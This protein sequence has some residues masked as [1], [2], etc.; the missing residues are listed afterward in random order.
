MKKIITTFVVGLCLFACSQK[1]NTN[2]LGADALKTESGL[3]YVYLSK[4]SGSNPVLGEE[5]KAHCILKV[6]DSTEIWNTR[7]EDDPYTFVYAETGFIKGWIEIMGVAKV[8]DRIKVIIPPDMGYG[9]G[10]AGDDIPG[11]A[12]LSFDIE[13]LEST[14]VML[15]IA[16]SL[17]A[18]YA[19]YGREA[20]LAFYNRLKSDNSGKYLL[21]EKQL[22]NLAGALRNDGRLNGHFEMTRLWTEEFPES[23]EAHFM[24]ASVYR[25]RGEKGKAI[26]ELKTCL[27]IDP[28]NQVVLNR[29]AELE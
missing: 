17:F 11:N 23:V 1:E 26:E 20:T 28:E 14:D 24:L 5:V 9:P 27:E 4:G 12:Y 19:K 21:N 8:G 25:E 16:D 18:T 15:W 3:E 6:G 10:G 7:T 22:K 29:L 2:S 13:V